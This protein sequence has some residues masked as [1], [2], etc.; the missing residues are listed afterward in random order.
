[1][2]IRAKQSNKGYLV[3]I[4]DGPAVVAPGDINLDTAGRSHEDVAENS[5]TVVTTSLN[6]QNKTPFFPKAPF[7][8]HQI[9]KFSLGFVQAQLKNKNISWEIVRLWEVQKGPPT[10]A[11]QGRCLYL[12]R[13]LSDAGLGMTCGVEEPQRGIEEVNLRSFT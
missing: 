5:S 6:R 7:L 2:G 11:S 1:M 3:D 10:W 4:R 9:V 8:L 12:S 13:Q